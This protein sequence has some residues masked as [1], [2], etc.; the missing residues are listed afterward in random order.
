[1]ESCGYFNG[2]AAVRQG[3][4]LSC[5]ASDAEVLRGA[6]HEGESQVSE[7]SGGGGVEEDEHTSHYEPLLN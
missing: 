6:G 7:R 4:A 3:P 2:P 5:A 1:M